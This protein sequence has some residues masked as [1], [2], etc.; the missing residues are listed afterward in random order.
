MDRT[1]LNGRMV[2]VKYYKDGTAVAFYR[3]S[4][5][6]YLALVLGWGTPKWWE[7]R[8]HEWL[9]LVKDGKWHEVPDRWNGGEPQVRLRLRVVGN[10]QGCFLVGMVGEDK[11]LRYWPFTKEEWLE[12]SQ[13]LREAA[14]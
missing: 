12:V 10:R 5:T 4:N 6:I 9:R 13:F 7:L 1:W 2:K 11:L 14:A 3:G 8:W